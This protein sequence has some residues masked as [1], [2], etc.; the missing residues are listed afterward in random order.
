LKS[1]LTGRRRVA[2]LVV[3][4]A[5]L[6]AAGIAYASIP[7]SNGVLHGCYAKSGNLR[8]IDTDL[9]AVCKK[10]ETAV[11]WNTLGRVSGL[12]TVPNGQGGVP[13]L[14]LG[15]GV[16]LAGGCAGATPF[17][18]QIDFSTSSGGIDV[19]G[20]LSD[21][22][23]IHNVN[24][25][26]FGLVQLGDVNTTLGDFTGMVAKHGDGNFVQVTAHSVANGSPNGCAISWVVTPA[27]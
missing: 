18:A 10:K 5:G 14:D 24:W 23:A 13:I 22:G 11:S 20:F 3:V 26:D 27:S 17:G 6:V 2:I 21:N 19:Y 12:T 25:V 8:V 7:D 16:N 4:V 15:N 1:V 9:G